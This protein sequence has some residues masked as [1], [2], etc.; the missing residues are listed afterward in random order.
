MWHF[1][2]SL[3]F[4]ATFHVRLCWYT[5]TNLLIEHNSTWLFTI[6]SSIYGQQ[7]PLTYFFVYVLSML[8]VKGSKIGPN[9]C[10]K[11]GPHHHSIIFI[12]V[13]S[14]HW[15]LYQLLD[16]TT[17]NAFTALLLFTFLDKTHTVF[18]I[19]PYNIKSIQH[20]ISNIF[21]SF[22]SGGTLFTY[23]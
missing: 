16:K 18:P 1:I 4:F 15:F 11:L 3:L 13:S 10:T 20:Q 23:T 6:Q 19:M 7:S 17:Q 22:F 8:Q 2:R 14:N 5:P 21:F 12:L 9:K